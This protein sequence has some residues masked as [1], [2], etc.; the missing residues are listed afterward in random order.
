[1]LLPR[2][3]SAPGPA[4]TVSLALVVAGAA[5]LAGCSDTGE[6]EG[7]G[8]TR[9]ASAP[10]RLWPERPPAP[11]PPPDRSGQDGPSPVPGLHREASG[12]IRKVDPLSVVRAQ[13]AA[14]ARAH[15]PAFDRATERKI[16]RCTA[17]P[18]AGCPVRAP[19]YQDLTHDGKAE[20]I[21]G[22]EG[23]E[24]V[25]A[26]WAY[27]L[28]GGVVNRILDTAGTPLSVEV[29][30]GDLIMREPTGSPGYEMRTVHSWDDKRQTMEIRAMEFD[31]AAS[32][33]A[34]GRSAGSSPSPGRSAAAPPAPERTR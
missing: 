9:I 26:V 20:L 16:L 10:A 5:A 1:M 30:D 31:R 29:A 22:I 28:R 23:S 15:S 7:A 11:Q 8:A 27:T 12:D 14:D 19:Q 18:S 33:P 24:H 21:V 25:L 2:S 4:R 34:P 3:L 17:E 32:S 6:P 13:I